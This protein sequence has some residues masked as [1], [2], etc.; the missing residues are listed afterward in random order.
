[1]AA[2]TSHANVLYDAE[3]YRS[4]LKGMD[5][6]LVSRWRLFFQDS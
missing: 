6:R 1:M 3:L 5:E 4:L 2:V